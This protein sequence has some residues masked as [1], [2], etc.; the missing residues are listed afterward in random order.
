MTLFEKAVSSLDNVAV[1]EASTDN[2]TERTTATTKPTI[3]LADYQARYASNVK[4]VAGLC[5][6]LFKG[7]LVNIL[8]IVTKLCLA[9]SYGE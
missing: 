2:Y 4:G 5:A 6:T 7:V 8:L 3:T 1:A 9:R